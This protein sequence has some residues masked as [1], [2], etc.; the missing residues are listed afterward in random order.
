MSKGLVVPLATVG[1]VILRALRRHCSQF[2][3]SGVLCAG[4]RRRD[5]P[6]SVP[7]HLFLVTDLDCTLTMDSKTLLK[8]P[9]EL[10]QQVDTATASFNRRWKALCAEH[11][12]GA[13]CYRCGVLSTAQALI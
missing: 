6:G 5:E 9:A 1:C 11:P 3:P 12:S 10:Q 7:P 8:Q 2:M 4:R 13:L